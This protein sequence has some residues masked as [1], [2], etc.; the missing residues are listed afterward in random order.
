MAL[1]CYKLLLGVLSVLATLAI[2]N[3][4]LRD[5]IESGR[6]FVSDV[7]MPLCM[8]LS[9]LGGGKFVARAPRIKLGFTGNDAGRYCLTNIRLIESKDG[10]QNGVWEWKNF[11]VLYGAG[12]RDG[13]AEFVS[14]HEVEL[15]EGYWYTIRFIINNTG[16]G[17][18]QICLPPEQCP[19]LEPYLKTGPD[20]FAAASTESSLAPTSSKTSS[21]RNSGSSGSARTRRSSGGGAGWFAVWILFRIAII[22]LGGYLIYRCCCGSPKRRT[23]VIDRRGSSYV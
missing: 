22:V 8:S 23:T 14:V 9:R 20:S 6:K 16:K 18:I 17:P 4:D 2:E 21:S 19:A 10:R 13:S 11:L 15:Q 3:V 1:C 12:I 5:E 7:G